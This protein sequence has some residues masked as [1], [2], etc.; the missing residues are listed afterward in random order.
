MGDRTQDP[1]DGGMR[2]DD[3]GQDHG[4]G[5]SSDHG[6]C[7]NSDRNADRN[8][9][10]EA[11]ARSLDG[12]R[13]TASV[14][15]IVGGGILVALAVLSFLYDWPIWG[16][17]LVLLALACL[18]GVARLRRPPVAPL[19]LTRSERERVERVLDEHG[20]RPAIA[21]VRALYPGESAA[22]ATKT[23]ALFLQR[24]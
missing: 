20:I 5:R 10:F 13:A 15:L 6:D 17:V 14:P 1:A 8:A 18:L 19:E 4:D 22:A 12:D 3:R 7:R 24:R 2:S 16:T 23:V 21:L 11:L 9:D